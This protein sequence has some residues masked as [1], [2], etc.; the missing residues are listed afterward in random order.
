MAV[1][2]AW[3]LPFRVLFLADTLTEP[4]GSGRRGDRR[5]GAGELHRQCQ[6]LW[7]PPR[8]AGR[9]GGG[10]VL[11]TAQDRAAYAG[12]RVAGPAT[13]ARA[14]EGSRRALVTA[15]NVLDRQFVAER[16]N[17][18]WIADFTYLWTAEGCSMWR[19]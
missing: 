2:C 16:P 4:E 7:R 9:A 10:R 19:P 17:Q 11:R 5:Q 14:A 18:K 12:E 13:P 1:R 6:D 8:L 3:G 15:A